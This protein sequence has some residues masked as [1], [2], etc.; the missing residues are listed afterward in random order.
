ME[1]VEPARPWSI[2]DFSV[3][4]SIGRGKFGNVY[5]ARQK[6]PKDSTGKR[7]T[8]SGPQVALKVLFK[9]PMV[10]ARCVHN[11]RREVEIQSA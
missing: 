8:G 9:A 5:S 11:L 10:A 2:E 7:L 1:A 4:K 6:M 3:G